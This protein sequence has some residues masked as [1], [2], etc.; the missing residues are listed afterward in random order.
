MNE[1]KLGKIPNNWSPDRQQLADGLT[2]PKGPNQPECPTLV[3]K[4]ERKQIQF[5]RKVVWTV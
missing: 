5:A 3:P 1:T 2:L 4:A